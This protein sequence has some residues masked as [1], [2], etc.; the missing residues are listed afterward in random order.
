MVGAGLRRRGGYLQGGGGG[1]RAEG[2][3]SRG[4]T[5]RVICLFRLSHGRWRLR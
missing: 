4:R 2:G 1:V 3:R 5:G